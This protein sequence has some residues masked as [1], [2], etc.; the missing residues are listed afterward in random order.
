VVRARLS[1]ALY[2]W[3]TDR[4]TLPDLDLLIGSA[5]KLGLD[6][7]KPLDQRMA[8]LDHLGVTSS[9]PSSARKASAFSASP[10]WHANWRRSSA[11]IP[12]WP[13][14]RRCLPRPTCRRRRSANSRNCRA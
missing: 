7:A 12:L 5:E 13:I 10:R 14:A 6:L 8:K 4:A 1:D 11:R 2:F 3:Q 9:T